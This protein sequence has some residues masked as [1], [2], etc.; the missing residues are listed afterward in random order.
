MERIKHWGE[1]L[2][3]ADTV[4]LSHYGKARWSA[5]WIARLWVEK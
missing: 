5:K 2:K 1:I 4:V 3:Q